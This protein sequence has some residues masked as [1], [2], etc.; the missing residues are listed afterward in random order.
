MLNFSFQS[1][2]NKI[3]FPILRYIGNNKFFLGNMTLDHNCIYTF[4]KKKGYF[5]FIT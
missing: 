4:M 3:E 5:G 2:I 1:K